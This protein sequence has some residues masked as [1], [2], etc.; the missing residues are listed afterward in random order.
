[1][2]HKLKQSF[3]IAIVSFLAGGSVT[4][5][6]TDYIHLKSKQHL[7]QEERTP[8]SRDD[9]LKSKKITKLDNLDPFDQ[10]NK[11][12]DQMRKRMTGILGHSL[13]DPLFGTDPFFNSKNQSNDIQLN[14]YEDG[15]YKYVEIS[16]NGVQKDSLKVDISNGMISISG[17]IK[18]EEANN[19]SNSFSKSS[20]IS[21]FSQSFNV[22]DGVDEANVQIESNENKLVIKF[23]KKLT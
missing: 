7:S 21:K 10:M 5:F 16:G 17:E 2:N 23:P 15:E 19:S 4:Y 20:Y 22:P 1:M 6:I 18:Q 9:L 3:F 8:I 14:E 13:G 11:I 12:H